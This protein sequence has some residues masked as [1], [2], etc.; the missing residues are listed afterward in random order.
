MRLALGFACVAV[1]FAGVALEQRAF[2]VQLLTEQTERARVTLA[3]R[4]AFNKRAVYILLVAADFLLLVKRGCL[5]VVLTV[6]Y[7]VAVDIQLLFIIGAVFWSRGNDSSH[8]CIKFN[9][10]PCELVAGGFEL[11]LNRHGI[12]VIDVAVGRI[13]PYPEH[14]GVVVFVELQNI[15]EIIKRRAAF[16]FKFFALQL[17]CGN[18]DCGVGV[19]L[20]SFL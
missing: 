10:L 4:A 20:G 16:N 7:Y 1:F 2:N 18:V 17:F 14:I 15:T 5:S 13:V 3:Y 8:L 9:L 6:V 19:L 12:A 11:K